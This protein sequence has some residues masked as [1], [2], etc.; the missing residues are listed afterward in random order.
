MKISAVFILMAC[1]FFFSSCEKQQTFYNPY[2]QLQEDIQKIDAYL[3]ENNIVARR[4][5]SGLRYVIVN[6][7]LGANPVR[8]NRVM[9]H[10]T[11]K[12]FDGTVFDSSYDRGTPLSYTHGINQ[13]ISGWDEGLS[14]VGERG[15][16]TL[17]VPSVLA[18]GTRGSGDLIGPNE[19]LIFDVE[20]LSVQ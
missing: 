6:E 11:G 5:S 16:I 17:Y 14:Y 12:L 18:Y 10:Y 19:N 13:V 2:T 7:G 20:L 4:S 1:V 8:G 15:K 9:V 3:E